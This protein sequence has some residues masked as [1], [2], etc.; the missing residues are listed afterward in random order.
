MS[1]RASTTV[2]TVPPATAC[3]RA[4][5][6]S[7]TSVMTHLQYHLALHASALHAVVR[8]GCPFKW[9]GLSHGHFQV[10]RFDELRDL[11][12][13]TTVRFDKRLLH[14][15]AATSCLRFDVAAG[16]IGDRQDKA[17]VPSCGDESARVRPANQVERDVHVTRLERIAIVASGR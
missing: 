1:M 13:R 6:V 9:K 16:A 2:S 5:M 14:S 4:S 11:L 15:H 10:T 7:G 3:S 12:E 8:I 17:S